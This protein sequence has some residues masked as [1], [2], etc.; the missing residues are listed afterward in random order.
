MT[1]AWLWIFDSLFSIVNWTLKEMH[2]LGVV[3]GAFGIDNCGPNNPPQWLGNDKL[4]MFAII[5][6]QAWRI[7]PVRR[8][9]LHRR[10]VV[11]PDRGRG[12]DQDRRR[13]GR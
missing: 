5:V 1:I 13:V 9:H 8:D 11:D 7:L 4:A 2:L 3:C 6:V 10:P 12:R